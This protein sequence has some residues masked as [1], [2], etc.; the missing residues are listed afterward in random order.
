MQL[1]RPAGETRNSVMDE[2]GDVADTKQPSTISAPGKRKLATE[3]HSSDDDS[4]DNMHDVEDDG[5]SQFIAGGTAGV[6]AAAAAAGIGPDLSKLRREKRLAMNRASARARRK[7]KKVLLDSLAN[8]VTELTKRNQA[9]QLANETLRSKVDQLESALAQSQATIASLLSDPRQ[10]ALSQPIVRPDLGVAAS[11]HQDALRA[12]LQVPPASLNPAAAG[13]LAGT[14]SIPGA[15]A[16]GGASLSE[17]LAQHKLLNAQ[18]L[19]Q[20]GAGAAAGQP[21]QS[22]LLEAAG[23]AAVL[24]RD[25]AFAAAAAASSASP[26]GSFLGQTRVSHFVFYHATSS[27][28]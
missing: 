14:A 7:R 1:S 8:Q 21:S 5:D 27:R 25:P 24:R 20:G 23:L 22:Q 3:D 18:L 6:A 11:A 4:S 2:Q 12:L 9:I 13:M 15:T 16:A 10:A 26:I 17:R 28:S 19:A